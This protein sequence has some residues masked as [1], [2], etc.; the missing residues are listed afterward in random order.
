[1]FSPF[2]FHKIPVYQANDYDNTCKEEKKRLIAFCVDSAKESV[3]TREKKIDITYWN[4][5]HTDYNRC[6]SWKTQAKVNAEH[7]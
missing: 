2:S 1:M 7:K 5:Y 3:R 6:M 4:A